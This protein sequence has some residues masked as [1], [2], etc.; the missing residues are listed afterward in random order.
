L[1]S[2][3]HFQ[4]ESHISIAV[5]N[6]SS[7]KSAKNLLYYNSSNSSIWRLFSAAILRY[8]SFMK[9]KKAGIDAQKIMAGERFIHRFGPKT[10]PFSA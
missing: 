1:R 9:T 5:W 4:V 7:G 8:I 3:L 6:N 2:Y 10:I